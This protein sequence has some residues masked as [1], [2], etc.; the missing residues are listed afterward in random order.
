MSDKSK[1]LLKSSLVFDA[2]VVEVQ[3]KKLQSL[4]CQYRVV[5]ITEKPIVLELAKYINEKII[6]VEIRE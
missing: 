4:D 3:A 5:L 1:K 2:E 6:T